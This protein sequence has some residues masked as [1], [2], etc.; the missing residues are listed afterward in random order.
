MRS[1]SEEGSGVSG[2]S[3]FVPPSLGIDMDKTT[4]E[5]SQVWNLLPA[6]Y[7]LFGRGHGIQGKIVLAGVSRTTRCT[8]PGVH[9]H[10]NYSWPF[11]TWHGFVD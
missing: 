5:G 10:Q 1:L 7:R 4:G 2:V 8:V 11:V 9:S 3:G 6:E